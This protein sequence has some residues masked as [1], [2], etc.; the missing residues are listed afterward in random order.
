MDLV[1]AEDSP[2]K[3]V[4]GGHIHFYHKDQLTDSL[5]QI[6]TGAAYEKHA[7]YVTLKPE[8]S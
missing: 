6:V 4:L 3:L 5:Q 2:I 8:S 1:T 7:L